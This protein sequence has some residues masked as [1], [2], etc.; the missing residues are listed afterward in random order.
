MNIIVTG[1]HITVADGIRE[2]AEKKIEKLE[3]YFNQTVN[4]RVILNLGKIDRTAEITINGDGTQF[5][6]KEKGE[7]FF[8]A[9]D[10]LVEK[11]DKQIVK[12]KNRSQAHRGPRNE[13]P[14]SLLLFGTEPD[15]PEREV[16]LVEVSN[17]PQDRIEA[18]L[19]MKNDQRDFTLFK[20]EVN[21]VNS[22]VDFANKRYAVLYKDSGS[23]K[24][25]EIPFELIKNHDFD[26]ASFVEYELD[27]KDESPVHP[28]IDFK[29]TG[30]SSIKL[31]TLSEAFDEL[32]KNGAGYLPFFNLESEYLNIVYKNGKDFAV[33]MP[34]V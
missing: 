27:I 31:M 2:Y 32:D 22:S 12:Y 1:R 16:K 34:A 33:M 9:I 23:F 10:L 14:S 11:I 3:V 4:V 17:K 18:Y 20:Q 25:T 28:V 24:M 6:G 8:A 26:D 30:K 5:Y 15:V 7:T 19:Q 21:A 13:I 29:E